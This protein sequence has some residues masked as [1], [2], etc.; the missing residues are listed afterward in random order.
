M[1]LTSGPSLCN[2]ILFRLAWSTH[3]KVKLWLSWGPRNFR[4]PCAIVSFGSKPY[5][6]C[7]IAWELTKVFLKMASSASSSLETVTPFTRLPLESRNENSVK[8]VDKAPSPSPFRRVSY[9]CNCEIKVALISSSG[10]REFKNSRVL[11][12]DQRYFLIR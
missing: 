8:F 6:G 2:G 5:S 1:W 7:C 9:S 12:S 4:P 10:R 3:L 11:M